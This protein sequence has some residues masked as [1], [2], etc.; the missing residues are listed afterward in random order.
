[1]GTRTIAEESAFSLCNT[2]LIFVIQTLRSTFFIPTDNVTIYWSVQPEDPYQGKLD[3]TRHSP[4]LSHS[5]HNSVRSLFLRRRVTPRLSRAH[6]QKFPIPASHAIQN[7]PIAA[8]VDLWVRICQTK[9]KTALSGY[10]HRGLARH[11]V[12]ERCDAMRQ[13]SDFPVAVVA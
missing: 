7:L 9:A 4:T 3:Q 12:C 13:R 6:S 1:M 11:V 8:L 2:D 10:A 5:Q